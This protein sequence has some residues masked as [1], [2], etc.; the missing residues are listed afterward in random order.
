ML[1]NISWSQYFSFIGIALL[2]YYI[3]IWIIYYKARIPSFS[4]IENIH[5][6]SFLQPEGYGE[7]APDEVM[8]TAQQLVE[9][10]RPV[11]PNTGNKNELIF[12]LQSKLKKF[13]QWDEPGFRDT[14]NEFIVRE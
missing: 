2:L 5:K 1:N 6:I 3:F 8:A 9:E 4:G 11:F 10:L 7:D 14:I 12:S 13:N